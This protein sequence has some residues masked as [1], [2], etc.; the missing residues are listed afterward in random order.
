MVGSR[1]SPRETAGVR[2]EARRAVHPVKVAWL[3]IGDID[4]TPPELNSRR[5]Y[6]E[7]SIDE[8]A[9]SVT[10]LGILQPLCVRPTG[11]RYVLVF[12]MRRL[13]AAVRAGLEE[14]PCTIQVADD[15]RAFLLNT[16]E[17][18][19]R[20]QLTGAERVRAI[21]KLAATDLGVR[22]IGRRTGFHAATISRW[23]KID[24]RPLVKEALESEI[25]DLG[26]AM[27]LADAPDEALPALLEQAPALRQDELKARVAQARVLRYATPRS[28]DSR[29]L[30]ESLRL[31][32][33]VQRVGDDDDGA[34]LDQIQACVD[35]LRLTT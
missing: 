8:L 34:L 30:L 27:A 5:V 16:V 20:R 22:E 32:T 12:G 23:L 21:E 28:V 17:N 13:R 14:V 15:D 11:T 29:R 19:H 31:L 35:R 4:E 1:P 3:P 18:L 24:R 9:A 2:A 10:E 6:D 33:L 25:L 26:R 7:T